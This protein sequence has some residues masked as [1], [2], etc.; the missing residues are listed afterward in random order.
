MESAKE[1]CNSNIPPQPISSTKE[2]AKTEES[3]R[4]ETGKKYNIFHFL[5]QSNT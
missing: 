2:P 4:E 3:Y 5:L 1:N